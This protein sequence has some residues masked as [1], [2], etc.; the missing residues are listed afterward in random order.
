MVLS[1]LWMGAW[2]HNMVLGFVFPAINL[3]LATAFIALTWSFLP[4]GVIIESGQVTFLIVT[5]D[6]TN[7]HLDLK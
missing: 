3:A 5:D 1:N 6:W 2:L 7:E 4:R